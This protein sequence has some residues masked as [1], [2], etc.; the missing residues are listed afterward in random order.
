MLAG[1]GQVAAALILNLYLQKRCQ[2]YFSIYVK[3]KPPSSVLLLYE[4]MYF[5]FFLSWVSLVMVYLC[6]YALSF[7]KDRLGDL[8]I[9]KTFQFL[10]DCFYLRK[11]PAKKDFI[12]DIIVYSE[13]RSYS[14]IRIHLYKG[15]RN[16]ILAN[17]SSRVLCA[18]SSR[19]I[20]RH[21]IIR[22]SC[23]RN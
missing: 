14:L 5:I 9:R 7:I 21:A 15:K 11:F 3:P 1:H 4:H 10:H 13:M 23:W 19:Y 16:Y 2:L 17:V 18:K 6:I 20:G 22:C 8:N 12:A